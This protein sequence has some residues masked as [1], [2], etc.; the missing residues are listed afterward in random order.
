M[1]STTPNLCQRR[2]ITCMFIVV[3]LA[4]IVDS[5]ITHLF[6][7]TPGISTQNQHTIKFSV[8]STM[9]WFSLGALLA[10]WMHSDSL[11]RQLPL[12]KS[13][14]LF[15]RTLPPFCIWAYHGW[16]AWVEITV[17]KHTVA[18]AMFNVFKALLRTLTLI[19]ALYI[20]WEPSVGL[21]QYFLW[22]VVYV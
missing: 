5:V 10:Q 19:I 18:S 9:V 16:A 7:L 6:L 14:S 11:T 2:P 15:A 12:S 8:I 17:L 21:V 3:M 20:F 22:T 4:A 13:W 1:N